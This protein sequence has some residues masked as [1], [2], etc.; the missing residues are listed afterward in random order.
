MLQETQRLLKPRP[1]R[2]VDPEVDVLPVVVGCVAAHHEGGVR[3][4]GDHGHPV[5]VSEGSSSLN[6]ISHL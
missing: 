6:D 2:V 5:P 1:L 3:S 4:Q